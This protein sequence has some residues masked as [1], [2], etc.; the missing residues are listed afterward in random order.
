MTILFCLETQLQH[1]LH[2]FIDSLEST[3]SVLCWTFQE[4]LNA[5]KKAV[6]TAHLKAQILAPIAPTSMPQQLTSGVPA[7]PEQLADFH[8]MLMDTD[9]NTTLSC[10]ND[11]DL[12]SL[13]PLPHTCRPQP[14]SSRTRRKHVNSSPSASS[15]STSDEGE[16]IEINRDEILSSNEEMALEQSMHSLISGRIFPSLHP[17]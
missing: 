15:F 17:H 8:H 9:P 13:Q 16:L 4:R 2:W 6:V 5:W 11:L 7:D 12:S 3:I 10:G 1:P 14:T